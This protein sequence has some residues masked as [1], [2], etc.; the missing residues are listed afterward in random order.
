MIIR[1]RADAD[2]EPCGAIMIKTHRL[3]G[4]PRY[5]RNANAGFVR[6]SAEISAWVAIRD[7]QVVGHV[8][9]H[10]AGGD[11]V[12]KLAHAATGLPA[13]ELAVVARLVV[14]PDV[15]GGGVGSRL[16]QHASAEAHRRGLRAALDVVQDAE[17]AWRFYERQGWRRLG[18]DHIPITGEVPLDVFVYLSPED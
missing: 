6:S 3:D 2:V 7:D 15:R 17:P 18:P 1:L 11:P 8:A 5:A 12:F 10:R 13:E 14:D 16:L 4:Y 9:L